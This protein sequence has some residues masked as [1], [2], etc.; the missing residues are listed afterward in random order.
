VEKYGTINYQ[1]KLKIFCQRKR[2]KKVAHQNRCRC[3][4]LIKSGVGLVLLR[5]VH[6]PL[7]ARLDLVTQITLED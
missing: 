6:V 7:L 3:S 5:I 1:A 2:R 4:F